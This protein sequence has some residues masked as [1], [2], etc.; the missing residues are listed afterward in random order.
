MPSCRAMHIKFLPHSKGSGRAAAAYLLGDLDH[1]GRERAD[2]QVLRGNPEMLG[3]LID[4]LDSVH[5]YTSGVIAFHRDDDPTD[6][7][8]QQVLTE[9]ERVAF[10]GLDPNQYTYCAVLHQEDDGSKHVHFVSP[11]VEL[12]TGKSM[13]IAPPGW[14][15]TF[16]PLRDALNFE[17]G[18]TRPDDP[19][20]ARQVQ[21]GRVAQWTGWKNGEDPRQQITDWLTAQV[22]AGLVNDRADVIAA[23]ET[24]GEIN[25]QGKDYISIR[26]DP[27]AKP[28]RLKGPIYGNEFD[29]ESFRNDSEKNA[30]RPRGRERPDFRASEIARTELEKAI[31]RRA[32]YNAKRFQQA[33]I[34][35]PEIER[36]EF[37]AIE[38]VNAVADSRESEPVAALNSERGGVE[39]VD[40]Q[41]G[42]QSSGQDSIRPADEITTD[43]HRILQQSSGQEVL[44]TSGLES[45]PTSGENSVQ[46]SGVKNDRV[47]AAV[48]A[49]IE[50]AQRAARAAA[51][52]V[53]QTVAAASAAAASALRACRTVDTTAIR[54]RANM[55]DEL[56]RFKS[57]ISL[58]DFACAEFG[59]ELQ[60]RES[61]KSS[62]V[63]KCGGDKIIVTRQPDGHDV[64]FSTGDDRD[65]GSLIDFLQRRKSL[66]LGQVRK[67]L[68]AWLP[69]AKRPALKRPQRPPERPQPLEKDLQKVVETWEKMKPYSGAYLTE[70]RGIERET[71]EAFAVRQDERGNACVAHKNA[72]GLTG[73]E[74]KNQGFT[75]FATGGKRQITWTR[76]DDSPIKKIVI[77]EAA[78]DCMSYFQLRHE[79]G[80]AYLSTAGTQLNEEQREQLGQLLSKAQAQGITVALAM[81]KDPA[82]ERMAAELR[83]IAPEGAQVVREAPGVGKD[84]NEALKADLAA[85]E[86]QH[87]LAR[88]QIQRDAP[89]MRM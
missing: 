33:A 75:G 41:S 22:A 51:R 86:A 45:A 74:S 5:R 18:W 16:D 36:I 12:T 17:H 35:D 2:V 3:E 56:S 54:V 64:Y 20:L 21:P 49:A 60:M 25:R 55:D 38:M 44:Q 28:I 81:D 13:N 88:R 1:Q 30:R 32:Q 7:E 80:T 67:E 8:I 61:S 73:W 23:L 65:C 47:R 62:R 78:I 71:I 63:L 72:D 37:E 4:S 9:F 40:G 77:C 24:L 50:S 14:Q 69:G 15:K 52:A 34:S 66:N 11:R 68:R 42:E 83:Q 19:R 10:A 70:Q 43:E 48:D 76:I 39:L 46:T 58:V 89:G 59:Y 53:E 26:T 57:E 31:S 82:G 27:G 29:G 6:T 79:P 87:E 84:W 85:Q